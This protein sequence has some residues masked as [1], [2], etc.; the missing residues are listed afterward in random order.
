MGAASVADLMGNQ[1]RGYIV[2]RVKRIILPYL[3]HATRT[4]I[5][6]S[7][8]LR[9]TGHSFIFAEQS[10]Q[11]HWWPHGTATCD[12]GLTKQTMHVV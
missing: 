5:H 10:P 8:V 4:C 9:Q 6:I 11:A 12:F 7:V 1:M 2:W 3:T